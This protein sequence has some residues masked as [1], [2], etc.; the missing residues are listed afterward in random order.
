MAIAPLPESSTPLMTS[1][2]LISEGGVAPLFTT[3]HVATI[4]DGAA[5]L[6][7]AREGYLPIRPLAYLRGVASAGAN[8]KRAPEAMLSACQKVLARGEVTA[9]SLDRLWL[10]DSY[11]GVALGVAKRLGVDLQRVNP[12]GSSLRCGFAAGV[13]GLRL[14]A[15]LSLSLSVGEGR[16]GLAASWS[17]GGNATAILLEAP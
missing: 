16:F 11:A 15:E 9:Q 17:E 14:A 13:E 4:A 2:A 8:G 12:L 10:D 3:A 5:A 7:I 6:L 1:P